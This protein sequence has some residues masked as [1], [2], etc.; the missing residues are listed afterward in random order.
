MFATEKK[1]HKAAR[2]VIDILNLVLGLAAVV[3]A[4]FTFLNVGQYKWMFPFIFAAGGLLNLLS[5]I[6]QLITDNKAR[7]IVLIVV[8]LLVIGLAIVCKIMIK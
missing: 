4:V 7:G 6:K 2:I 5:G 8:G 1:L 3:M